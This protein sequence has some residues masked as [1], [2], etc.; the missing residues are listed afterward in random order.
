MNGLWQ[1]E[2]S[3]VELLKTL[4]KHDSITHS[5]GEKSFPDLVKSE[6]L[7]L[8]YFNTHSDHIYFAH[9]EDDR[10]AVLAHYAGNE[11][12]DTVVLISHFD[13]V[14]IDDFGEYKQHAFNMDKITDIFKSDH[15][16]LNDD[17][18]SDIKTGHYYFGRGSMDMKPG[19]M[20]HM[21]LIEKAA[22]ENWD[23]NLLLV[24]VP[25]EEVGSKGMLAAVKKIN[26]IRKEKDLNIVLHLNSEP[27]FQQA[28]GNNTHY[29]YTG[30]IGKLMPAVYVY[31]KETHVGNAMNGLSSNYIMSFINKNMEYNKSFIERYEG[32][33]TPLPVS[34]MMR[35]LKAHYD[36]QTPFRTVSLYNLFIFKQNAS[37]IFNTFNMIVKESVDE[38]NEVIQT[39]DDGIYKEEKVNVNVCTYEELLQQAIDKFGEDKVRELLESISNNQ[40]D[41]LQCIEAIDKIMMLLRHLGPTVVT[42]FTPP[43]YPAT[44]SSEDTL[45]QNI[46][47]TIKETSKLLNR[48]VEQVHFFNGICDLSYVKYATSYESDRVFSSNTP[49]FNKTYMIPFED[50]KE[51]SAP[52]LNCGPIGKD[53]HKVTERL[54]KPSA[55]KELPVVLETVIKQYFVK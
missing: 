13:T 4:V 39:F 15:T 52:V 20:L 48:N 17:A 29:V 54:L 45:V 40:D 11:N 50:I 32:E 43:Y 2:D 14:G 24:T 55:F 47:E 49:T 38:V 1:T 46:V 10:R 25:D 37:E 3:R 34:L 23:V 33:E 53:A 26:E 42:F 16:Y 22:L 12:N 31:G 21:S 6:L 35:D 51:I 30:T 5:T 28:P 19:L 27:T 41:H 9:T 44:N 36:V 18:V 8:D 7:K